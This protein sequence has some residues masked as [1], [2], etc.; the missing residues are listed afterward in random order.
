VGG[1]VAKITKRLGEGSLVGM[2][3]TLAGTSAHDAGPVV[4][5]AGE[6]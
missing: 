5:T 1:P 2:H 4:V 6:E 3:F